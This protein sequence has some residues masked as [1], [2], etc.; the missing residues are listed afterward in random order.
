MSQA[1]AAAAGKSENAKITA[2]WDAV[3]KNEGTGDWGLQVAKEYVK[4]N[5]AQ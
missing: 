4:A 3:R 2:V 1:L 5:A